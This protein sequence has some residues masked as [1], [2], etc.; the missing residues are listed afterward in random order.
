MRSLHR[1]WFHNAHTDEQ[2][3]IARQRTND[4]LYEEIGRLMF[5]VGG[6]PIRLRRHQAVNQY[7]LAVFV[8]WR[9]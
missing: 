3:G 8:F 2:L 6:G 1:P 7:S 4:T 9:P 5:S